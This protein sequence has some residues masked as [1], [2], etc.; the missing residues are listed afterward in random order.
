L[1]IGFRT[2]LL[3]QLPIILIAASLGLWLFYIH[4]AGDHP[5]EH[6]VAPPGSVRR[7]GAKT[8]QLSLLGDSCTA[9]PKVKGILASGYLPAE[10]ESAVTQGYL[11]DVL[12]KPYQLDVLLNKIEGTIGT[13]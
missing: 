1:T 9:N 5:D 13:I 2:Y 7:K 11:C 6:P 4:R 3:I 12:S 10:T 8:D